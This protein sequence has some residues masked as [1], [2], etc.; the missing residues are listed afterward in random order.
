[1]AYFEPFFMGVSDN[2]QEEIDDDK[3]DMS[4]AA[5]D[6][7]KHHLG[8]I[9]DIFQEAPVLRLYVHA[10]RVHA[11]ALRLQQPQQRRVPQ[12]R[13]G[14][15]GCRTALQPVQQRAQ[16]PGIRI[17]VCDVT[18]LNGVLQGELVLIS[19]REGHVHL[20]VVDFFKTQYRGFLKNI[21]Y[22]PQ[23]IFMLDDTIRRNVPAAPGL[24]S[25]LPPGRP[26]RISRW[27]AACGR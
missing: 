12:M 5:A 11:P 18:Q 8:D 4:F 10:V 21:G 17:S 16:A 23:M 20:V 24:L 25:R 1:M 27:S 22:I 2:L 6:Q 9:A 13:Q 26:H 19:G 14:L 15:C 7:D 3:V